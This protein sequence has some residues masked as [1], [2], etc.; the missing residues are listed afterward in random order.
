[1][2]GR[3]DG[4]D[5]GAGE[6]GIGLEVGGGVTWADPRLGLTV[7]LGGRALVLRDDY[8]EW[9]L[10][11]LLQLDPNAAGHG[12]SLRVR[13]A[14]GVTASGVHGLWE[15]G[16]AGLPAGSRPGGRVEA[17]IGYGL[18]ALG[19]TGV[20][21]PFARAALTGTGARS[22]SLGGR[23]ALAATFDLTLQATRRDSADP[24]APPLHDLTLQGSSRW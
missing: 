15:R 22:L 24:H 14:W 18:P 20:L 5:G 12:L 8:D 7:A 3:F 23:L 4:G 1:M 2:G 9:G 13:P 6:T 19:L 21:T 10:S 17:E 16:A 11:G